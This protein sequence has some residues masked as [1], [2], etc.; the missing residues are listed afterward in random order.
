[1]CAQIIEAVAI[2]AG[3]FTIALIYYK[4]I[5]GLYKCKGNLANAND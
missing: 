1:M 3:Y 2:F 5:I 4:L